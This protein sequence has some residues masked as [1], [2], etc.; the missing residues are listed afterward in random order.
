MTVE[1]IGPQEEPIDV[2]LLIVTCSNSLLKIYVSIHRLC[3]TLSL[4][5]LLI[6]DGND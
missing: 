1:V 5:K 3:A 2:V 6:A 4:E